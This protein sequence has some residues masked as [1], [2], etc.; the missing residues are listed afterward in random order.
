MAEDGFAFLFIAAKRVG[1]TKLRGKETCQ[2][3]LVNEA[4]SYK[5]TNFANEMN[6]ND[7]FFLI[8]VHKFL[9]NILQLQK[10]VQNK[11]HFLHKKL[12]L[13]WMLFWND[14]ILVFA[15]VFMAKRLML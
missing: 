5:T 12:L 6:R 14:K 8:L 15:L 11:L 3:I 13:S 10:Q 1:K 4:S 9:R 7:F 2:N